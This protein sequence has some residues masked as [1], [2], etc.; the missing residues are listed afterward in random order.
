MITEE[1]II[2]SISQQNAMVRI[3]KSSACASCSSKG[4]CHVVS[5]KEILIE[6]VN[7]LKAK[8]GDRVEISVPARS[9]LKLSL[10]VYIIP[11]L[12]LIVGAYTGGAWAESFQVQS[13]LGAILGGGLAMGITFYV[14][15][16]LD[17]A[18]QAKSQYRPRMT[19]VLFSAYSS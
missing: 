9:L 14:L 17:R 16:K 10:L 7:D 11:I 5:E 3:Q 6:V 12:A 13:T 19:R 2:E 1:G 15:R 8:V 4:A 18:A